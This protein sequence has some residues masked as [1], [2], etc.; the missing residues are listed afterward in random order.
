[1]KKNITN[2]DIVFY[3]IASLWLLCNIV[4]Y[5]LYDIRYVDI[6]NL[7]FII[8]MCILIIIKNSCNKFDEWLN[9]TFIRQHEI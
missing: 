2:K 6:S 5:M 4:T 3:I 8:F 1:M 7:F 9:K